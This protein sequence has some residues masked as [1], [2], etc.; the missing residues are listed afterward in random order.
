[1]SWR[2]AIRSRRGVAPCRSALFFLL[3]LA[4]LPPLR[5]A[6]A[7]EALPPPGAGLGSDNPVLAFTLS[8]PEDWSPGMPFLDL[9]K[10]ARPWIGH[11]AAERWGGMTAA[12]L[13]A[14]G[15]LDA[16]GW[17]RAVPPGAE[18]VGTVFGWGNQPGAAATRKG[19]YVLV[20]R[21]RGM[22]ELGGD[23][24][25]LARAPGRIVFELRTGAQN[26]WL[27]ILQTD[28]AGTGD[29]IRD[30]SIVAE[31][32]LPLYAAGAVFNPDWLAL[33]R[34]AR[35]LR[36]VGWMRTIDSR[37][38]SWAD[39]PDPHG[40][41]DP[42]G[43]ALEHMVRLANEAG[44]DPW[45]T[46]PHMADADY[47]RRFAEYVR[48][49]LDPR[50]TVRVEWSNEVWNWQFEETRWAL[51]RSK[52]EWGRAAHADYAAKKA[53]ETAQ[54]WRD[55]FREAPERL[56]TVLATQTVNARHTQQLLDAPVWRRKER[57]AYVPPATV[58]DEL[59]VTT[60][61]GVPLTADMEERAALLR[62]MDDPAIDIDA[63][64]AGR[65]RDP[66]FAGGLPRLAEA[67]RAQKALARAAGLD[68]VLYEGGQHVHQFIPA[69]RDGKTTPE[70][71]IARLQ[72]VLAAF[73]RSAEMGALY[74][75]L[76]DLWAEIGEGPFMQY[77]DISRPGP[78]GSW[79][80]YSHLGDSTPRARAVED[81]AARAAPWWPAEA[82]PHYRQGILARGTGA[83]ETLAGTVEEDYL[84]GGAGDDILIPGP[85]DDG[86]NGGGGHDRA[87]I[88]GRAEDWQIR[89]EGAGLR[90]TGPE[91]SDFLVDV[92]EIAFDDGVAA[93]PAAPGR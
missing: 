88:G 67:L 13:R 14:G 87:V 2:E 68:L 12:E 73:C 78:Y 89:S 93:V 29:Y 39:R 86:I 52:A 36:F 18:K 24:V 45:F 4:L 53:V 92:E 79:G 15:F 8:T 40:P 62:A 9:M 56:R 64:I 48:D 51:E 37:V 65:L 57:Q 42:R 46:M 25:V 17:V 10:T 69:T 22:I 55:V 60:Y 59:A 81:L 19:L 30:M 35:V 74:R 44:A 20:Y 7:G 47:I 71:D 66:A 90:L 3:L 80:L 31:R 41:A 21:G 85:G 91:G 27:N 6:A 1:M 70:A 28:P 75:E 49:H 83:A 16:E 5:G 38:V 34:E 33:V 32:Y 26:W 61:F 11:V 82:G 72:A 50:L 58:F 77:S 54:I 23:A 63:H 76:W 43:V 84:L